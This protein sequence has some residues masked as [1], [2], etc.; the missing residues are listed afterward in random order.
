MSEYAWM[1][2]Y[3][4]NSEYASGP[5]YPKILNMTG[6]SI[7]ELYTT[8]WLCQNMP[9]QRPKYILGSKYAS[10]L[11]MAGLSISKS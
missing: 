4:K 10:I 9:W 3:K 1:S 5:K 2:L 11:N 6:L 7:C 8:F